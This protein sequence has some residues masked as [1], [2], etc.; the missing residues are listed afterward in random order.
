[1][2]PSLADPYWTASFWVG[3]ITLGLTGVLL[4]VLF[5]LKLTAQSRLRQDHRFDRTWQP[6]LIRA[7][8]DEDGVPALPT[9]RPGDDWRLIKLWVRFQ[10][11]LKGSAR[12][13]LREL[14]LQLQCQHRARPLLNSPH[15][16]EQIFGILCLGYLRD[17]S[18][19]PLLVS[20]LDDVRNSVFIYVAWALL[21]LSPERASPI[22]VDQLLR[23]RDLN[24]LQA[25]TVLKPFRRVL[26]EPLLLQLS[27][28]LSL[29]VAR[30]STNEAPGEPSG[31]DPAALA[32]LFRLG[33]ALGLTPT[34]DTLR[35]WLQADQPMDLII[36]AMR[37][38]QGPEGLEPVRLLANHPDW[39]VRT[40]VAVALGRLG[41]SN[42][43][44]LLIQLLMDSQWWVRYRAAQS[45]ATTPFVDRAAMQARVSSLPD[46]YARDM[47]HQVFLEI[48]A[49]SW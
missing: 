16:S 21:Q 19:W 9:L 8:L 25:S 15:R 49:P 13:R 17:D 2:W 12:E 26:H 27:L 43:V 30:A 14:G 11:S 5:V 4:V 3:G 32:W 36:G 29:H 18:A 42:D 20:R 24:V 40:Q 38:L 44:D 28:H 35:P 33:L 41:D 47:A 39:Q 45:L 6:V 34:V 22:V 1:M 46:R 37:L 48:P 31:A 23:R 10:S 7:A